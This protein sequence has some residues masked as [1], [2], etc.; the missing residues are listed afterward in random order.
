MTTAPRICLIED[1]EIMGESL[2]ERFCIE[3]IDCT[4]LRSGAHAI[5]TLQRQHYDLAISD[6]RLGDMGGDEVF[7]WARDTLPAPP[8]FVFITGFGTVDQAVAL[9]RQGARDYVTKPFDLDAFVNKLRQ[10][11][12]SPNDERMDQ[13]SLGISPA[14]QRIAASLPRIAQNASAVLIVGESGVG[15]EQVARALHQARPDRIERPFIAVNCGAITESL[16]EA[17]LF[18]YE[19]GAFTGATRTRPGVF[20]Q[21]DGGTLFLDEIGEMSLAMQVRLLRVLQERCVTRV[22]GEIRVPVEILLLCATHR[23][24]QKM[25][26]EGQFREDL[27]YRINVL[28]IRIPPLRQRP[29][30]IP[31]LAARFLDDISRRTG[32]IRRLHPSAETALLGNPWPGNVRELQHTLERAAILSQN[33]LIPASVLFQGPEEGNADETVPPDAQGAQLG[34]YLRDCERSYILSILADQRGQITQTAERLGI[35]R[36]NLWEK[37]RKLG[38]ENR[39]SLKSGGD[40]T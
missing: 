29:E 38:I 33:T 21:A 19:K 25:V 28:Q 9:I 5:Q 24:L 17:E 30:D 14:M 22:G 3:G 16:L 27:Y 37:M 8:P 7:A 26:A 13:T 10:W 36:K 31:W 12:P 4:W 32:E 34:D 1:D 35:S 23:N 18:G 11:M 6:L 2:S 15:K 20:E 39:A 40:D